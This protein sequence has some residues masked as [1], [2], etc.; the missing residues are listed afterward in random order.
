MVQLLEPHAC[1]SDMLLAH[2]REPHAAM[3]LLRVH[4]TLAT[5]ASLTCQTWSH[6]HANLSMQVDTLGERW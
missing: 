6:Q 2:A 1:C 3:L 4:E 5:G